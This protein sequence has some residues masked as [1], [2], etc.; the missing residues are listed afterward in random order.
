[1][2]INTTKTRATIL[3]SSIGT[4]VQILQLIMQFISRTVFIHFL[5]IRYLGL[6]G[7][8]LNLLGYLNFAELGLGAAITYALYKP[9][10]DGNHPQVAAI[11]SLLRKWYISISVFVTIGGLALMPFIP[12]L[13]KGNTTDLGNIQ[14]AFAI[15]LANTVLSYLVSYKRTLLIA[16][17][18][19]YVNSLNTVGYNILGQ[20]LQIVGLVFVHSFYLYLVI[21]AMTMFLSN[22]RISH[23]ANKMY[24]YL[25]EKNTEPVDSKTINQMKKNMGGAVSAKIGGVVV[26]GMDNLLLSYFIGVTAVGLYSNYTMIIQGIT[27]IVAQILAG[28]TASIGHLGAS[29]NSH[30]KEVS[31]F[32]QYFSLS[33]FLSIFFAIGFVGFSSAFIALWVGKGMLL[34]TFTIGVIGINFLL[35]LIR[36]SIVNYTNAYGLYW[37]ERWKPLFE[38]IVN[39]IVS[40][41]LV[42]YTNLGIAAVLL[43]TI[44]SNLLVNFWWEPWIVI[45]YGIKSQFKIFLILYAAYIIIGVGCILGTLSLINIWG[46]S[47]LLS[48]ILISLISVSGT[49]CMFWLVNKCFYPKQM[50]KFRINSIVK[51]LRR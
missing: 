4:I 21:Q 18:K 28:A 3:N 49:S 42:K 9:L 6:N 16:D 43:G 29:D 20:I 25:K 36:Q 2:E 40:F 8:F 48:G 37:Y 22:L 12:H 34:S 33:S 1:M 30:D 11:M 41:L 38:A 50:V 7:L 45:K 31:V 17:Q 14:I 23:I 46:G 32:Y 13:I 26:N 47:H 27:L 35:Q 10:V 39:F 51:R 19:S 44:V 24:P 5:G 15:S